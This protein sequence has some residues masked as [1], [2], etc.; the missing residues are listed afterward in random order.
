MKRNIIE[1]NEERCNGCGLCANACHEGAIEMINGKAKLVSDKYCDGLGHC[2]PTCPTDA[3]RLIEKET[4][5]YDEEAVEKRKTE[6]DKKP[7]ASAC[8][9]GCPG[10]MAK[11]LAKPVMQEVKPSAEVATNSLPSQLGQWPV[12][13]KLVNVDA[14]YFDGANLLVAADCSAYAYANFHNEFIKDH[15]TVIGCPKLDDNEYYQEKL[16]E[17]LTRHDIKSIT[18]V[19]MEVPC[20]GGMVSTV[21]GAMLKAQVIVPYKEVVVGIDGSLK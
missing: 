14:D 16:A 12:Q 10:T 1:I 5:A 2:L 9:G 3:I 8:G 7:A 18:V 11:K 4:V 13:L 21:R 20:C 19:R 15:I 17:I 6:K